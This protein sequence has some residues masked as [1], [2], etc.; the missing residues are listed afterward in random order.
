MELGEAPTQARAAVAWRNGYGI[1]EAAPLGTPAENEAQKVDAVRARAVLDG[2][3]ALASAERC[4][5]ERP[6]RT[7]ADRVGPTL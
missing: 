4:E 3:R 7:G 1:A 6:R 5:D 2:A